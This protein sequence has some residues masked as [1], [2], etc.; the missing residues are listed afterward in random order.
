MKLI[1]FGAQASG[2]GTQAEM[3]AKELG[4]AH[5][6][7]GELLR[8][9]ASSGSRAGQQLK[10]HMDKG[11]L[12]PDD[13]VHKIL[14]QHIEASN[15]K[16]IL[17]GFP[18]KKAQAEW[19]DDIT[20]IDRVILLKISDKTALER[21]GGRRE[22]QKG[23]NYHLQYK[24]PKHEGI[25]DECGLPLHQRSDDTQIA[26]MKRLQLFHDQT[27]PL[28]THYKAK[29]SEVNGEQS[30]KDVHFAVLKAIHHKR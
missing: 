14:K 30:I 18:R 16:F 4:L 6:S 1:I 2:K 26:I 9:E 20:D 25:C 19:L 5:I 10:A 12:V 7:M 11:E 17:D 29:L 13:L 28:L 22:C 24:P 8:Q 15:G 23:H 21:I 27:E 3:L